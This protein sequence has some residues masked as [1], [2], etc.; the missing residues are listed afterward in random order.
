MVT[1]YDIT[2]RTRAEEASRL[3]ASVFTHAREGI[4]IT[5]PDGAIIDVNTAFTRITGYARDEVLGRNPRLLASGRHDKAFYTVLWTNLL[6]RGYWYGEIWN[7]R[8]SGEAYAEMI[9]ISAVHDSRGVI[10][11]FVA[12]FSDITQLKEH[13]HA[14]ER[15]A[16]YDS[17]THLPNRVL[18][19]DRLQ[20][21]MAQAQRRAQQ[22]AVVFIDLD[23]FKAINDCHGHAVGDQLLI[24]VASRMKQILRDGDT[25]ARLG[26]DE[27]I[28][29]LVDLTQGPAGVSTLTRLLAAV[30]EPVAIGE[31][32]LQVSAS[33]G[34]AFHSQEDGIAGDQLI[35]QADQ[36][37]YQAKL[38]GKNRFAV[39]EPEAVGLAH[40]A[41]SPGEKS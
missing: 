38:K 21:T 4:M 19:A 10:R 33:L 8:K 25:L 20:Q 14:L 18:L 7:R 16:H 39:F 3:A 37:M 13:E 32:V 40:K 41:Q 6:E 34:V 27:F 17:L 36:A 23:G 9:T 28:A 2:E 11:H 15:L 31:L 22:F 35:R 30:A 29:V 26:G 12:L 5:A 1:F 24:A